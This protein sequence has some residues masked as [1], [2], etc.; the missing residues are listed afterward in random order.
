M[1]LYI[2]GNLRN[3][4]CVFDIEIDETIETIIGY[5]RRETKP[6]A[7]AQHLIYFKANESTRGEFT[8]LTNNSKTFFLQSISFL[9]I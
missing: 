4:S 8:T 6:Q 3:Y 2:G 5:K 7:K 1:S 9:P